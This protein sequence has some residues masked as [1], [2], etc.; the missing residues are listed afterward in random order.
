MVFISILASLVA[1]EVIL[2]LLIP[3]LRAEFQWLITANDEQPEIPLKGLKKFMEHGF[4]PELGWV[5]K[6]NTEASEAGGTA[7]EK[8]RGYKKSSYKINA[9][10]ARANPGH[11]EYPVQY[12]TYGDSFVFGRQ[13]D[14]DQTWQWYLSESTRTNVMNFGVGNYGF[15]QGLLRLKREFSQVPSK[16]VIMG[17]V[18]ET[19]TRIHSVWK[20]YYEYGNILGFKPRF[21]LQDRKLELFSNPIRTEEDFFC[22]SDYLEQIKSQDYF[23]EEKFK[24][25]VLTFPYTFSMFKNTSRTFPLL[26]ALIEK[27]VRTIFGIS[28]DVVD[29]KPWDVILKQN[30]AWVQRLYRE[31]QAVELFLAL[32]D[33][34]VAVGRELNF[35]PILL[36]MPYLHDVY[37]ARKKGMFYDEFISRARAKLKVIDLMDSLYDSPH[38]ASYYC[39]DFYG[40]H[41]TV[42]GNKWCANALA[43]A[44]AEMGVD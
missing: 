29:G 41:M 8:G 15:D 4:D 40:G 27:K 44:L 22:L 17:V 33:E 38:V 16:T 7:G 32:V 19:I 26:S 21:F 28:N 1:I 18:P 30:A 5:R 39:S 9:M 2:S 13:V 42:E 25:D 24:K 31:P 36:F 14:D 37:E 34:F 23:Y 35:T 43:E 3:K 12:T 10:G 6:P 11:E 20:H